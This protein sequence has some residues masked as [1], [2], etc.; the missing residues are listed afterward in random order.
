MVGKN[1]KAWVAFIL[2]IISSLGWLIPI[3]GLPVSVVGTALGAIGIKNPKDRGISVAAFIINIAFL[4][5]SIAK[6]IV[7]IC[8]YYKRNKER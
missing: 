4:G 7:D 1:E 6:A 8:F 3:I 2:G 5:A